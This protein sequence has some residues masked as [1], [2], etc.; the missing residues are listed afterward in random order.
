[1]TFNEVCHTLNAPYDRK[2]GKT[3]STT[4]TN[5]PLSVRIPTELANQLD[6][7]CD[8]TQRTRSFYTV[9]ALQA[10]LEREAWQIQETIEALEEAD[11]GKF[12][13]D[14]DVRAFF[15]K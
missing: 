3:M 14:A 5:T 13:P 11:A 9:Q 1:M 15:N 12:A 6:K 8:S 10:F 7:L 2:E 4:I